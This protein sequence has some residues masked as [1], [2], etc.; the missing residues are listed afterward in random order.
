MIWYSHWDTGGKLKGMDIGMASLR[1]DGFG[2]L[3]PQ[4]ADND[5]ELITSTFDA[6]RIDINV[7]GVTSEAPLKAELLDAFDRPLQGY[8]A[9]ITQNAVHQPIVWP[10]AFPAGQKVALRLSFPVNSNA[11]V[12]ALYLSD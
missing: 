11:H 5:G 2:Y 12:F 10:K 9:V 3:S 1:R 4:Q 7:D 6:G 8:T